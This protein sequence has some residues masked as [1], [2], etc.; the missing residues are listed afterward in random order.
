MKK[1]G[2]SR[3]RPIKSFLLKNVIITDLDCIKILIIWSLRLYMFYSFPLGPIAAG[4]ISVDFIPK[5]FFIQKMY[6][7]K[8]F[9]W[10]DSFYYL[11]VYE[12]NSRFF[13]HITRRVSRFLP[14][15]DPTVF[16]YV[17]I[18]YI[19]ICISGQISR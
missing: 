19:D 2:W 17:Q 9:W 10:S 3:S 5:P 7:D 8:F 11:T 14:N 4:S 6:K 16:E 18:R 12:R 1:K 13:K 15:F